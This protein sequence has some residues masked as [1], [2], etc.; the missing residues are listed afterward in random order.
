MRLYQKLGTIGFLKNSYVYKFLFVA[1][2]GIHIPLI[3]ILFFVIYTKV[4]FSAASLLVFSLIITLLATGMT[5][6]VLNKLMKPIELASNALNAYRMNK[7]IPVLPLNHSDEAGLLLSNIHDSIAESEK[8]I[9]EKQD[10]IYLLSHDLKTFAGHPGSLA[11]LILESD[12]TEEIKELAQLICQSSNEQF[13]YIDK[14]IKMLKEQDELLKVNSEFSTINLDEMIISIENQLSRLL[15]TKKISLVKNLDVIVVNLKIDPEL[16]TRVIFNI[17][18][19]AIKFS[20]TASKIECSSYADNKK[21][22]L[23]I[24]DHGVGFDTDKN[25]T[26]F[27][28]FTTMGRLGTSDEKSTG[29][30]LYLCKQIIERNGGTLTANSEGENKGACFT[31]AFDIIN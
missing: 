5:L 12:P 19:N 20:F 21:V 17:M 29:L 18:H 10:L 1:F 26:I 14:F 6:F 30:G 11:A 16:L 2:I 22:Y 25:D 15:S 8:F 13:Q 23:Q 7:K 9:R 4:N 3:G 27:A 31:I 24:T 28:K